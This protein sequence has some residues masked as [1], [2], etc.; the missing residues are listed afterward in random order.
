[1]D[2]RLSV[3]RLLSAWGAAYAR[4]VDRRVPLVEPELVD[5]SSDTVKRDWR[6]PK[7]WL[8]RAPNGNDR[9][10]RV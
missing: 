7:L 4:A 6:P 2:Q 10:H 5:V 3:T 8:F 9:E 1:M